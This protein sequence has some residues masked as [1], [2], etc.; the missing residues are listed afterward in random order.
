MFVDLPYGK[1]QQETVTYVERSEACL[2]ASQPH[3][4]AALQLEELA[5]DQRAAFCISLE[6]LRL[7]TE[8]PAL[9]VERARRAG[10]DWRAETLTAAPNQRGRAA[11]AIAHIVDGEPARREVVRDRFALALHAARLA[12]CQ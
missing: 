6:G 3:L 11:M 8:I 2:L 12:L 7:P 9:A 5:I 10:S 1:N 4:F